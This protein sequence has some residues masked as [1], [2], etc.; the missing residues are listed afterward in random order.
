[1]NPARRPLPASHPR[2]PG[3]AWSGPANGSGSHTATGAFRVL[4]RVVG[5]G[6]AIS[7]VL[8]AGCKPAG[9]PPV[10]RT[11]VRVAAAVDTQSD[12]PAQRG[13]AY[14]ATIK[15]RNQLNL[16]FRVPGIVDRIGPGPGLGDWEEGTAVAAG[17][18][19][20]QL[21]PTDFLAASNS[22][23][24]QANLDHLQL[25]RARRL[26]REGA[27][28]QQDFERAV[29]ASRASES[30]LE[31]RRQDL[32]D[33][34]LVAPFAGTILKREAAAGETVPAGRTVLTLADLTEVEVEVGL[35]DRLIG[36]LKPGSLVPVSVTASGDSHY[37]GIVK[38]V[39]VAAQEGSRLFRVVIRL[40]NPD[41]RL[42]PGMT[43][44]VHLDEGRDRPQGVLVPLSSLVARSDRDL[45]VFVVEA[46]MARER[47]VQ[48]HD[49]VGS[50]IVITHGVSAG[51]PVV[52]AGASQ[53]YDGAPV[54]IESA[55]AARAP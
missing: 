34:R 18:L 32:L 7:V 17:Q 14:L 15:G 16:S 36:S 46:G 21:K 44:S 38:E 28:A 27:A 48:T 1:M 2:L 20:A 55:A 29:A 33:S 50:S 10:E 24:A 25:E 3:R 11:R 54:D 43:A 5:L 49:I 8:M 9:V 52:V 35:P 53:L 39:G 4:A 26:L 41:R 37:E 12:A 51:E 22:A 42:R 19:L 23:A 6:A 40:A 45:A 31:L 30:A 47:R 13:A